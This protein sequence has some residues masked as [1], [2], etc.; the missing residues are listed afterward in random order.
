MSPML[1]TIAD[2]R[3]DAETRGQLIGRAMAISDIFNKWKS[4]DAG[5]YTYE[6]HI[7]GTRERGAG[8]HAS[9]ISKCERLVVYNL[10]GE[11]KKPNVGADRDMDMQRRFDIGHAIH[12]MLQKELELMCEW[13]NT[14]AGETIMTYEKEVEI[15]PSLQEIAKRLEL[16]SHCDGIITFWHQG[17]PYLRVGVEIKSK[18]ADEFAKLKKPEEDHLE[19]A[20]FYMGVLDLPLLFFIYYNKSNSNMTT[21]ESPWLIPFDEEMWTTK[22]L[23][24]F[25]RAHQHR[26]ASTLPD[27]NEGRHCNWCPFSHTCQPSKGRRSTQNHNAFKPRVVRT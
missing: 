19:Q 11:L 22:L 6:V 23:P 14:H 2:L 26:A 18:S 24:L 8:I 17:Q 1:V 25:G 20:C 21:S 10:R 15:S 27:R 7:G 4:F 16:F 12:A 3:Q 9:E 13:M 5:G